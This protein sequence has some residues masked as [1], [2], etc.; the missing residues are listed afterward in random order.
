MPGVTD[1]LLPGGGILVNSSLDADTLSTQTGIE[2]LTLPADSLSQEYLGRPVPN[3]ALLAAFITLTELLPVDALLKAL[4]H[5]F[6]GNLLQNNTRLVRDVVQKM[7]AG[8]WKE[9]ANA[10]S[11]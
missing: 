4:A 5:R 7:P 10:P 3:T 9:I 2:V 8:Q 1:G 11:A 6:S